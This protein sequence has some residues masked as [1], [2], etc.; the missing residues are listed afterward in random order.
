MSKHGHT[1]RKV[2]LKAKT[3]YF[4]FGNGLMIS[5]SHEYRRVAIYGAKNHDVVYGKVKSISCYNDDTD[6]VKA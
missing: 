5:V 1:T 6:E 3:T 2:V 4:E